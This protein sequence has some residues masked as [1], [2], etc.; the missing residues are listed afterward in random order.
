MI[1]EIKNIEIEMKNFFNLIVI[2]FFGLTF[3]A[4]GDD[5]DDVGSID[6]V[7]TWHATVGNGKATIT[8]TFENNNTGFLH[9][10][11]DTSSHY[12]TV[13]YAFTYKVSGNTIETS[14]T[15]VDSEDGAYDE[16]M[17]FTYSNGKLSGGRWATDNDYSK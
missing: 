1:N 10:C 5:D 14:G 2:L 17:K 3:A 7:G 4:C 9:Y 6:I 16:S 12:R 15:A 11:W 13:D 8:L